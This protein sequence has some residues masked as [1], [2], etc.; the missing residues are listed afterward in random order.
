VL[1]WNGDL[2]ICDHFVEERWRLG[3]LMETPLGN[4]IA[5]PQVAEFAALKTDLPADCARANF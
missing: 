4:L 5:R 3:N 1:E 2:Y